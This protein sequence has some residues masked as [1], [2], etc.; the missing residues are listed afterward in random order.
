MLFQLTSSAGG[1][2][3][4]PR[5]CFAGIKRNSFTLDTL[6]PLPYTP[7]TIIWISYEKTNSCRHDDSS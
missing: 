7:D 1:G 2:L 4:I 5:A 6:M 3:G